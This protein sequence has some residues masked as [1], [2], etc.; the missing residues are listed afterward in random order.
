[1]QIYLSRPDITDKEIEAVCEV[2]RGTDLSLGPKLTEFEQAF[3]E[4]IG[5]KRAIAV[6][7]G[8]SGLFL[9]MLA[10]GIN[11]GD[12]VITT[13]FTF[14]SSAT[15]IMMAG[16]KPVFVD[17]NP[18]NLNIDPEKIEARITDRTKAILPVEVFGNPASF[19]RISEIAKKH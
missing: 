9:S 17:I 7:S 19:D 3:A 2:L 6:N 5:S 18:E 14:I 4:Y 16:A 1:M 15:S 11:P 10:L 12:E 8:T 13:P